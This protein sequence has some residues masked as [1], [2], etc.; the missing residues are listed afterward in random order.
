MQIITYFLT[1][2]NKYSTYEKPLC[3]GIFFYVHIFHKA[4]HIVVSHA[5]GG[6]REI[7]PAPHFTFYCSTHVLIS[8]YL[9]FLSILDRPFLFQNPHGRKY[10]WYFRGLKR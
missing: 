4:A 5:S 10:T 2:E 8:C 3:R 1:L 9:F 6:P 7:W